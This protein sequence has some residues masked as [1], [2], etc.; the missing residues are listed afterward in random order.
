MN[1]WLSLRTEQR[2]LLSTKRLVVSFPPAV[3]VVAALLEGGAREGEMH[4]RPQDLLRYLDINCW[5]ILLLLVTIKFY[6][7]LLE[8]DFN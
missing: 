2:F 1:N 4:S 7:D 3:F 5:G 6:S 8:H